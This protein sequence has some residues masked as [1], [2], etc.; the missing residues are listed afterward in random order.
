MINI[1]AVKMMYAARTRL[2]PIK[3]P[4]KLVPAPTRRRLRAVIKRR[5]NIIN[6]LDMNLCSSVLDESLCISVL[7]R[8]GILKWHAHDAN[9]S[10]CRHDQWNQTNIEKYHSSNSERQIVYIGFPYNN[11]Y[12]SC[13]PHLMVS[14]GVS[15]TTASSVS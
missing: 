1:T 8:I 4:C 3:S 12:S 14:V 10:N 6:I 5:R 7:A 9:H 15:M 13:E 11:K 2:S